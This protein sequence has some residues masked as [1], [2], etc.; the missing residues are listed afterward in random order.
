MTCSAGKYRQAVKWL[1]VERKRRPNDGTPF[2][3][4]YFLT[5]SFAFGLAADRAE[6]A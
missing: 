6:F 3:L 1:V 4:S 5:L 2:C